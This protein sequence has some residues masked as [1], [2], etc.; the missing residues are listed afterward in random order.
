[1]IDPEETRGN[2]LWVLI[3][4]RISNLVEKCFPLHSLPRDKVPHHSDFQ[5]LLNLTVSCVVLCH[6][7]L[8]LSNQLYLHNLQPAMLEVPF[9][10]AYP[11][12][13]NADC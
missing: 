8:N 1:M 13:K 11:I 6:L 9:V 12:P 7:H 10:T 4:K 3:Q 5:I 2:E